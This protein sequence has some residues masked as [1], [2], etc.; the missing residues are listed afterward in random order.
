MRLDPSRV[1][2]A[3]LVVGGLLYF[4]GAFFHP[5]GMT[6]ADMLVD[7]AWIPAHTGVFVG[8][9]LVTLGLVSFRRSV[10]VSP[11]PWTLA[12]G[13]TRAR[14]VAGHRDGLAYDGLRGRRSD[15]AR[16]PSR[17]TVHARS[18]HAYLAVHPV[19]YPFCRGVPRS[20]LDGN[21]GA[22][23]RLTLDP[24]ARSDR[25]GGVRYRD[26]ACFHPPDQPGGCSVSHRPPRRAALVRPGR[27]LAD[28]AACHRLWPRRGSGDVEGE[29][30]P[31]GRPEA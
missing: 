15:G 11:R 21:T 22:G 10:A 31:M 24:L 6:M 1:W 12:S 19:V 8:F 26:V 7:P 27:H 20:N 28:A 5:R 4:F 25:G 17:R 3:L 18:D 16:G 13:Y 2:R 9:S 14:R 29:L 30:R 23:A